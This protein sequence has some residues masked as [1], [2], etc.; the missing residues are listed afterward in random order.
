[1]KALTVACAAFVL[2]ACTSNSSHTLTVE[3]EPE[4]VARFVSAERARPAVTTTYR[5]GEGRAQFSVPTVEAQTDMKLR[6]SAAN[7][8][9]TETKSVA[10]SLAGIA[11]GST[12]T[13]HGSPAPSQGPDDRAGAVS[14][15]SGS[16][17]EAEHPS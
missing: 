5:P 10:W 12:T 9:V 1:M 8:S 4:A 7:L 16:G 11:T 3:G 17:L 6:A 14:L 13:K 2:A 15:R